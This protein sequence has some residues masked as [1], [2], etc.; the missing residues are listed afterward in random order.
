MFRRLLLG[1]AEGLLVG[2]ALGIVCTRELGLGAPSGVTLVL[3]GSV[4]GAVTGLVA[5]RPVWARNA[6]VEALLKSAVGAVLGGAL[7][8]AFSHWLKGTLDLRGFA[9]GVGPIGQRSVSLLPAVT[10]VLALLFELDDDG[11]RPDR[12]LESSGRERRRMPTADPALDESHESHEQSKARARD[13][14]R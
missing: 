5:G 6:K 14:K 12:Q 4:A 7:S 1:L 11:K 3:L 9:L 8:L 13:E 10:S 2:L